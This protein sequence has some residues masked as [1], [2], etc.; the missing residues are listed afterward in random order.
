MENITSHAVLR[1]W[2][3][4]AAYAAIV[5][6]IASCL[7]LI[8]LHVVS[9]EFS[10][11]WRMVSEYALG[12]WPRVLMAVFLFWALASSAL[13]V[14]LWPITATTL[15]KIGI[16]FLFLSAVGQ[17]MGGFFDI[18]HKLHGPAAMIGIP[19]LC[20]AAITLT[21]ALGRQAQIA[22]PPLWTAL[23]PSIC[24]TLMLATL[25]MFLSSLKGA[26]VDVSQQGGPLKE[27]P[28]GV[29]TIVG[30]ANR[31]IFVASYLW[32]VLAAL[33]VIRPVR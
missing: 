9:P 26:G 22:A 21:L 4:P 14:A 2:F 12:D 10:P 1:G 13:A 31:L 27:L 28:A 11:S 25:F 24:F 19:S 6:T 16:T 20:I 18:N 3:A 5:A 7:C 30:W 8:I 33:S 32:I 17:A 23:L 29:T 15:G